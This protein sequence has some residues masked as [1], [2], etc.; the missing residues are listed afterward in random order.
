MKINQVEELVG[1]SKK[2]IRFYEDQGIISPE[3][4]SSNGYRE[5]SLKDVDKLNKIKLLR[6]LGVPIE[7]I[8]Q[9]QDG[10]LHFDKCMENH[11]VHLSHQQHE[12]EITK[13]ICSRLSQQIDCLQ[14]LEPSKYF[15]E[16][17]KLEEG[18]IRFMDVNNTDIKKKSSRAAIIIGLLMIV[19]MIA[20]VGLL[21]W[22]YF[23]ENMPIGVLITM[24]A[25]P[26]LVVIGVAYALTQ[27]IKEIKGGEADEAR[28]Y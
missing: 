12:L 2:N 13:E 17:Q 25:G 20:V 5:Y 10:D 26:I 6:R 23:T 18:G 11:A 24:C 3:R 9:L 22:G 16:M 4:N 28:K 15:D 8:R 14:E 7:Q 1:I 27:R 19:L 21:V